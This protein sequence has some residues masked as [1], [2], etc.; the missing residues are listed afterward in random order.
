[1]WAFYPQGRF[2]YL[3]WGLPTS[4]K[5]VKKLGH[6]CLKNKRATEMRVGYLKQA[7]VVKLLSI[8]C[9]EV[10]CIRVSSLLFTSRNRVK[11]QYIQNCV[12]HKPI[13]P[14][15]SGPLYKSATEKQEREMKKGRR[16]PRDD[17]NHGAIARE[18]NS[19]LS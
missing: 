2:F 3:D 14:L 7:F 16:I 8:C 18:D 11:Y 10:A 17:S 6:L 19:L 15:H 9:C 12:W 13:P 4:H 5:S 1:M